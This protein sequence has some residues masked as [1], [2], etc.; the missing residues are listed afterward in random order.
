MIAIIDRLQDI[1]RCC[2]AGEQL[3]AIQARW[4]ATS[5]QRFLTH[6]SRTLDAALGLKFPQGGVPWWLE[7]A[8]RERDGA[9][10]ELAA[11]FFSEHSTTAKARLVHSMAQRYAGSAWR[12]DRN[13][14]VMPP[15]Y[16]GKTHEYLWH[17]FRSGAIMPIGERQLRTVFGE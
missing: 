14:Q 15:Q 4:L 1:A 11:R 6:Q 9:L 5:L 17:A 3:D 13:R 2:Q 8:I 12:F 16:S 7:K 10:R